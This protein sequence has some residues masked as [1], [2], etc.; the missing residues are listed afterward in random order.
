[1]MRCLVRFFFSSR[2]RHTRCALVTGV[3]TC[4]LPI[5]GQLKREGGSGIDKS[6]I[7][8]MEGADNAGE[9]GGNHGC[10][11]FH[12]AGCDTHRLGSVF[13]LADGDQVM[14]HARF[15][16]KPRSTHNYYKNETCD[17]EIGR[18]HV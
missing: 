15:S 14:A 1:M 16:Y 8:D 7:G 2:R 3:Q 17:V 11:Y 5:Y 6:K 12:F 4:A 9:H 18:A 13:A 10:P